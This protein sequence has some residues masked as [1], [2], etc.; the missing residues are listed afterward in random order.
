MLKKTAKVI[1]VFLSFL[2]LGYIACSPQIQTQ[3][4]GP[5]E[6]FEYAKGLFDKGKYYKA[7]TEFTVIVLKFS[8]DP[9][10]DDA[11]Y[12]LAESYFK[13][14]DYL[15]AVSEYQKLINDYPESPYVPLAQ[16]KK[17]MAY[18]KI[19]SRPEL[20][21]EYT[22]KALKEFQSFIEEYPKH[23]LKKDAEK[24]I[25]ELRLKLAKK[26]FIAA[27]TYRKMGI[28]DSAVIYYDIIL[29]QYYDTPEAVKALFWKGMCLY[30][31]K[32]YI[33]ARVVF[34]TFIEKYPS[35]RYS[36]KAKKLVEKI[37]DILNSREDEAKISSGNG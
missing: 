1:F 18:Y 30:E 12:Y 2:T 16:F 20:D 14:K 17:A 34:S 31:M 9:V 22:I 32:K 29:E 21:Q 33:E 19:S 7:Q 6:Y 27:T 15:I 10:V 36:R 8:G 23:E 25:F 3:N 35:H 4:L 11:Q 26:K 37:T 13:L 24:F 5:D 28:Y